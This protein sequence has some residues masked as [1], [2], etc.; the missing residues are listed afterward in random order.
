[1][2]T[3]LELTHEIQQT[4]GI[5]ITTCGNCGFVVLHK[6][7]DE[8]VTCPHCGT[9]SDPCDFPDLYYAGMENPI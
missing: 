4:T 7:E 9:T 2:K 1:M 8:A 5:N 3:Q 6:M